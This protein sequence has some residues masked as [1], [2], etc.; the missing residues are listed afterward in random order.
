[1]G[2]ETIMDPKV[3]AARKA[4]QA[5][6]KAKQTPPADRPMYDIYSQYVAENKKDWQPGQAEATNA[7]T[8]IGVQVCRQLSVQ[9]GS[10]GT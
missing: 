10:S 2:I 7:L 8:C 3:Q 6:L 1:M 4:D 5:A 9:G